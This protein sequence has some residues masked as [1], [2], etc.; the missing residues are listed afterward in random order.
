[1][2][3]N[4]RYDDGSWAVEYSAADRALTVQALDYHAGPLKLEL[5]EIVKLTGGVLRTTAASQAREPVFGI[6]RKEKN[7]Y[8]SIPEGWSGLLKISRKEL[9]QYGKKMGKRGMARVKT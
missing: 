9:Y 5:D 3:T 6:S 7:L 4:N 8:I 2:S 1:M